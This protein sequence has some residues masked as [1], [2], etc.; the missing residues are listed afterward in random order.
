MYIRTTPFPSTLEERLR[1]AVISN[2]V[3]GRRLRREAE[4][5]H[6]LAIEQERER[7]TTFASAVGDCRH[8]YTR[9]W[10]I[11]TPTCFVCGTD[12]DHHDVQ[13]HGKPYPPGF[14]ATYAP[15][16]GSYEHH[17]ITTWK[18]TRAMAESTVE[19]A[20]HMRRVLRGEW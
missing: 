13:M 19:V 5:T 4:A 14:T 12:P 3:I 20:Q 10:L 1:E 11:E 7:L 18:V 15:D 8:M 6:Q 17:L 9:T 2:Y 16:A